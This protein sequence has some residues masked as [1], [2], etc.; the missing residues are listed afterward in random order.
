MS[1]ETHDQFKHVSLTA[2]LACWRAARLGRARPGLVPIHWLPWL[3]WAEAESQRR[4]D[5]RRTRKVLA[6]IMAAA[7]EARDALVRRS[8]PPPTREQLEQE[9]VRQAAVAR[10]QRKAALQARGVPAGAAAVIAADELQQTAAVDQAQTWMRERL[11]ERR[12]G[13]LG[14]KRLLVLAGKKD[15]SK[16]TAASVL[17][18][19]WPAWQRLEECP[20][21][22]P[23]EQILGPWYHRP[24]EGQPRDELSGLTRRQLLVAS[25]LVLDDVGQESAELA[26]R[27]GEVLD[28]LL[29]ARCDADRYTV[30]TTNYEK[31]EE[32]L[33]RYGARASRIGERI[34]EFGVWADCPREGLRSAKRREQELNRRGETE[35]SV[36]ST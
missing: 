34:T 2:K 1:Q 29:K 30:I 15:A 25:L 21:L 36:R 23:F 32:L 14:G 22:V 3:A 24:T 35:R 11:R 4:A 33:R 17:V 31:G 20:L 7:A 9:R 27:H 10:A 18:E 13:T 19:R 12:V 8:P 5:A 6:G 26:D 28:Q 16:T